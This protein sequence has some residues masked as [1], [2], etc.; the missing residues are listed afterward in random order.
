MVLTVF[1]TMDFAARQVYI[2]LYKSSDHCF[3]PPFLLPLLKIF[4][5]AAQLL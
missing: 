5:L 4:Q 2:F 3:I 1:I